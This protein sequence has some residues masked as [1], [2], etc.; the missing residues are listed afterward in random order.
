MEAVN[1]LLVLD[2]LRWFKR[3]STF[4]KMSGS[5]YSCRLLL[6]SNKDKDILERKA[7]IE[8]YWPT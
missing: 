7:G 6:A 1:L 5:F 8:E 4:N 3:Y 2:V